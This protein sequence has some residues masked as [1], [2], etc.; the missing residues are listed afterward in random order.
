MLARFK[1]SLRK[2]KTIPRKKQHDWK[3]LSTDSKL[4]NLNS[5]EVRNRFELLENESET[6]TDKYGRFIIAKTR[7]Q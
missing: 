3:S 2:S 5:L 1:L 6:A 4:Q 7:K